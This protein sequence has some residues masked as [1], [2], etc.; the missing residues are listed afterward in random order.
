MTAT[1]NAPDGREHLNFAPTIDPAAWAAA[2]AAV[3]RTGG[4]IEVHV[5]RVSIPPAGATRA[6]ADAAPPIAATAETL[7]AAL[8]ALTGVDDAGGDSDAPATSAPGRPDQYDWPAIIAEAE[9]V[10]AVGRMPPKIA[11]FVR[12]MGGWCKR[13]GW[14]YLPSDHRL[15][16]RLRSLHRAAKEAGRVRSE[17]V[18]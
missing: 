5:W 14:R 9:R 8:P 11:D 6:N 12:M 1:T 10:I 17:D 13:Q 15:Y 18:A 3:E 7:E 4:I 16:E 2:L